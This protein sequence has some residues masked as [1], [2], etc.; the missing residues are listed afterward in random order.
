MGAELASQKPSFVRKKMPGLTDTAYPRFKPNPSQKELT[1]VYSPTPE[2]IKLA[3]NQTASE[4]HQLNFLILLKSFQ[5]L[6]YFPSLEEIPPLVIH[7]IAESSGFS[8]IFEGTGNYDKARSLLPVHKAAIRNHLKVQKF[9]EK[10]SDILHSACREAA[11]YRDDLV[12]IINVGIEEL[13]RLRYELPGF[14][15]IAKVATKVRAA[16]N[17]TYY[18]RVFCSLTDATKESLE[19]LFVTGN[20][21]TYSN[22]DSIKKEPK[23]AN[24]KQSKLLVQHLQWLLHHKINQG[25]FRNIPDVKVK[26]FAAQART[27]TVSEMRRFSPA[28]RLTLAAAFVLVKTGRTFDDAADMF[29][30]LVNKMHNKANEAMNDYR[31]RI[32]EETDQLISTLLNVTK[33][34]QIE[35]GPDEKLRAIGDELQNQPESIIERCQKHSLI[36]GNNYLPFIWKFYQGRRSAL[37]SFIE[38]VELISTSQDQSLVNAIDLVKQNRS[39][40]IEFFP[41]NEKL[42]LSFIAEKKWLDFIISSDSKEGEKIDKRA[43]E[44]CVFSH[45]MN[46]LKSG[47]LCIPYS[48]QY[49]DYRDQLVS[50]EEYEKEVAQYC[51]QAG[52]SQSPQEFVDSLREQLELTAFEANNK[53]P[54]NEYLSIENGE[55]IL[56]RLR[57]TESAPGQAFFEDNLK[58]RMS[59]SNILDILWDTEQWLNWTKHFGPI[60]GYEEKFANARERYAVTAFCY[61]CNLGPSQTAR[62][63]DFLDRKQIAFTNQK[64]I[65][66]QF[67]NDAI[68]TVI[69]AYQEFSLQ[70]LWGSGKSA[71]ADGMKW[72]L[73]PQNVM[74]EYH[75]RYGGYGGIGYYLVSD[76]YIALYSRFSTCGAWEGHYILDFVNENQS[77]VQP[78]T[79]HSDTH[80]QSTSIFGLAHMLGIELMPRIRNWK[81]LKLFRPYK[82]SSFDHI[83]SLFKGTVDWQLI[84]DHFPDMLRVA[85]SVKKGKIIPSTILKRL[86]TYSRKNK[87]YYAYR[88]LGRVIRTKFILEFL[89]DVDLRRTIQRATNKSEAF[90][91]FAQFLFFGGSSIISQTTREEQRKAIKYNHLVAN[92]VIFH[93]LVNMTNAI[94]QLRKDGLEFTHEQV[95]CL[96]PYQTEQTNRFGKYELKESKPKPIEPILNITLLEDDAVSVDSLNEVLNSDVKT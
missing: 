77:A 57:A 13:V 68:V 2:E 65:T 49:R 42:D 76:S 85:I 14:T 86:A 25:I 33:A 62:S 18:S 44:V 16:V 83:D 17:R 84:R 64:H 40:R 45:I 51:K 9:G 19:S 54:D 27:L 15:T 87:L 10:A 81:N 55:A 46:D 3:W 58:K 22:W 92:L 63:I 5:R 41:M 60:S 79:I 72:E 48:D 37:F 96:S 94:Q 23:R 36:A 7:H 20:F 8:T 88:E 90:N 59:T 11:S 91:K 69:N 93:N 56:K 34:Y 67:L 24:V 39:K 52:L 75:I 6:G 70:K 28:K 74:S 61:G 38:N 43:F 53:F 89:S 71:S 95:M 78:D 50:W 26:Q 35:G 4:K 73:Y 32:A 21:Y 1:E 12:D 82:N 31:I 30:K 47:D 80:G 66:E 29:I